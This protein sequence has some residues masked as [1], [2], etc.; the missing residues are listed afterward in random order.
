MNIVWDDHAIKAFV[1]VSVSLKI[2]YFSLIIYYLFI[3]HFVIFSHFF[4]SSISSYTNIQVHQHN[5]KLARIAW[6][7]GKNAFALTE[8]L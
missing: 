5:H 3:F 8:S 2:M 4:L 7:S 1:F 6:K